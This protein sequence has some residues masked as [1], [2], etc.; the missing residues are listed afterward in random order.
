MSIDMQES[1]MKPLLC[2]TLCA[3]TSINTSLAYA[4]EVQEQSNNENPQEIEKILVTGEMIERSVYKTANSAEILGE[5]EL[6]NRAGLDTVRDVLNSAANVSVVTGTGKAPTVRGIDGTGAAENANAFFAG[7]RSRLSWLIDN[8]PAS[9]NEVVFGDIGIFD[10]E[11]IEVLKGAQSTLV[12]RNAIAG[13]VIVNTNDPKF[14]NEAVVQIATGNYQQRRMSAM[15]NTPIVEDQVAVRFSGDSYKRESPINYTSYEGVDNPGEVEALSLRGK[16][17]I[18]PNFAPQSKLLLTLS[19]TDYTA[20]NSQIIV[21]PFEDKLSNFPQQPVH[22][23]KTTSFS[24]DFETE[25]SDSTRL[26]L[27]ASVTDFDFKRRAAP[28]SSN[29][30]IDTNEVVIEPRIYYET[31]SGF[32]SVSGLYYYQA[33]QDEFIEILGAQN[34]TDESD[35]IAAYSEGVLPLTPSIQL[36]FGLRYEQDHHKR[37]GGDVTGEL[38]SIFSDETYSAWLPKLGVN[39]QQTKTASWGAQISR[40]YNAGGGGITFA[41][42]IVNYEYD[43]EYVWT[44]ELYGRQELLNGKLFLTQNVFYSTYKNMQ[45]P[46]DLTPDDSRDEAFVVRNADKVNT[47]GVELGATLSVTSNLKAF[48]N[49]GLLHTEVSKYPDSGIEGNELLTAPSV[50]SNLGLSWSHNSWSA[51]MV[52][53]STNGH[54]TD[55]NNRPNGK[56]DAYVAADAKISYDFEHMRVYA[57]IKNITDEESTVALYPGKAPEGSELADNAFDNAV[58][59]Q[60]RTFVVGL[61]ARF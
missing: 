10:L 3:V 21:Q 29:A 5:S 40:G 1:K 24:A 7:S 27:S 45:L 61:E 20:P 33:N 2:L 58:L 41:F 35:S 39:W 43:S 49:L 14:N 44:S 22:N 13:T 25:L 38:V 46:F 50:T 32:S 28:N 55:V 60:P 56:T 48:V 59:I 17:L 57:S 12:G 47:S 42:P 8:R 54:F 15:F 53:R 37:E 4:Q 36:S 11:R 16:V 26:T 31:D 51:S 18:T 9:Y 52:A 23:P 34:F 6:K 30:T 19:H